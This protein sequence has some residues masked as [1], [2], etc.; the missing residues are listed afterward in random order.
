MNKAQYID[1]HSECCARL[2]VIT[3]EKNHDYTGKGDDP[4][5]NFRKVASDGVC[6]TEVGFL[7][8][9]S[10]KFSRIQSLIQLGAPMVKSESIE[11]TLLDLANYCI[12]LA[13]YLRSQY[14]V[15]RRYEQEMAKQI[16][17]DPTRPPLDRKINERGAIVP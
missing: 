2:I 8:R 7:V 17:G 14:E 6:S 10:D 3:K 15:Q 9:M 4:F 12:L 16:L 5:A 11:D 13:G 1:F